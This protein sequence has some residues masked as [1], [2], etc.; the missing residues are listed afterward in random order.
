MM[1]VQVCVE[2][3]WKP[4]SLVEEKRGRC[5]VLLKASGERRSFPKHLVWK[6]K[7]GGRRLLIT[8]RK[9]K[10]AA[11]KASPVPLRPAIDPVQDPVEAGAVRE[12]VDPVH[13]AAEA[14]A[15]R[16]TVK[17]LIDVVVNNLQEKKVFLLDVIPTT[18]AG[19]CKHGDFK[20]MI[21]LPEHKDSL[22]VYNENAEDWFF[23]RMHPG[24]GNACIRPF[25]NENAI[26][27]PTGHMGRGFSSLGERMFTVPF[28]SAKDAIDVSLSVLKER[29]SSGRFSRVFFSSDRDGLLGCGIF[30]VHPS[31]LRYITSFLLGLGK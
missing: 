7:R 20:W 4:A 12:K 2:G 10:V 1:L 6:H 25:R 30:Y 11:K 26:G 15:V 23:E 3:K 14:E 9:R 21:S 29:A 13:G 24:G 18:F 27:I 31:V 19:M 5:N 22:F 8:P 16:E 17:D 28:D